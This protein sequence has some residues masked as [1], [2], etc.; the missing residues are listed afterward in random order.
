MPASSPGPSTRPTWTWA[1][2]AC[3]WSSCWTGRA[4]PGTTVLAPSSPHDVGPM[5]DTALSLGGPCSIRFPKTPYPPGAPVRQGEG[6]AALKVRAAG[7]GPSPRVCLLGVGKLTS[8][9]EEAAAILASQ[10]LEASV[11]D[12]RV[13]RPPDPAMVLDARRH[14][15]VVVAEDGI[16]VGGAGSFLSDALAQASTTRRRPPV[17]TL[18]LPT[19]T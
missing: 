19:P 18:G 17:L 11:W 1:C 14:D 2:T 10:G 7:E 16:R 6:L 8:A 13:V 15:L 12:V 5:L 3:R 9:C 4:S